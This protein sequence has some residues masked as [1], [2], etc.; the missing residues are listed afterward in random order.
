MRALVSLVVLLMLCPCAL[1]AAD[2]EQPW[3]LTVYFEN[4][5]FADT[6][7]S[8]TNGVRLSWISPDISSYEHDDSLPGFV[9][10][11]ND[12]LHFFHDINKRDCG[13]SEAVREYCL[14][15][16]LVISVGQLMFTPADASETQV[17]KNDRPYA[18]YLYA[19]FGYHT[20]DIAQ[21]DTVEVSLGVVGPASL[22]KE[23]QDLIHDFRGIDRFRGWE[24]Q[25]YNEP[26]FQM[27][28]EH[29]NRYN[30]RYNFGLLAPN[31]KPPDWLAPNWYPRHDLITHVGANFGNA[32]IY[33]NTGIEYRIG[34]G[35]PDDFGS[36]ALRPG[37]DNTA[38]GQLDYRRK[39]DDVQSQVFKE[40]SLHVFASFDGRAVLRDIFLDGNTFRDSHSVDKRHLVGDISLGLGM[41]HR[42]WKLSLARVWRSQEYE[43]QREPHKFGSISLSYSY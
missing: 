23:T 36:G 17:I 20:R 27:L 21:L 35:L 31:W 14:Q 12:N 26:V 18:G 24:R 13:D 5:L 41:V 16:N 7:E 38:P 37:G 6:D 40:S 22:A 32:A 34:L 25:L 28:Y 15:R 42:R 2:D 10:R 29:K 11:I 33:A 1:Q 43:G 39:I 8:Y 19:T 3:T 30:D 4:D 9:R